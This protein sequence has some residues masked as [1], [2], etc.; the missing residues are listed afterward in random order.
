LQGSVFVELSN[1][2]SCTY[3]LSKA[4]TLE[5]EGAKLQVMMKKE[6]IESKRMKRVEVGSSG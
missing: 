6:Y 2:E 1:L 4:N 5:Y 3:L